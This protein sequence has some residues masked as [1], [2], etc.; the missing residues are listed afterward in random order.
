LGYETS[1]LV[2]REERLKLLDAR[3]IEVEIESGIHVDKNT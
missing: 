3:R 2:R 1:D